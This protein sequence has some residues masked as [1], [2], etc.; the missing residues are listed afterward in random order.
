MKAKNLQLFSET[1][2]IE[3]VHNIELGQSSILADAFE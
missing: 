1:D 3:K 2:I